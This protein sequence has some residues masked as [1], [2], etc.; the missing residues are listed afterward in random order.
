MPSGMLCVAFLLRPK[1]CE[2]PCGSSA[3]T[4]AKQMTS[5]SR[6]SGSHRGLWPEEVEVEDGAG[7]S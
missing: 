4:L 6:G 3:V 1:K 7:D 2:I 5:G